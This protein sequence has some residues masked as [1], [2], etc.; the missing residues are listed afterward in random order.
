MA[1]AMVAAPAAIAD[2]P[3]PIQQLMDGPGITT[4]LDGDAVLSECYPPS[5]SR[6]YWSQTFNSFG[7]QIGS[8]ENTGQ[9]YVDACGGSFVG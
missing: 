2:P 1:L 5:H 7:Q 6:G 3:W 9:S 8:V 4:T